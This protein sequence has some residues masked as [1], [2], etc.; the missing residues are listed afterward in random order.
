MGALSTPGAK[1]VMAGNPTRAS[2]FFYD[3][4]HNHACVA[5]LVQAGEV[6]QAEGL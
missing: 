6:S 2:G 3:T 4:H 1:V 5:A